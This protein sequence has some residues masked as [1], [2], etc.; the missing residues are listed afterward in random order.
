MATQI[1]GTGQS[2]PY[3]AKAVHFDGVSSQV[4]R[5]DF[6]ANVKDFSAGVLSVWV[7]VNPA[8]LDASGTQNFW[9]SHNKN[10]WMGFKASGTNQPMGASLY[11]DAGGTSPASSMSITT[12]AGSVPANQ[13]AHLFFCWDTSYPSGQKQMACFINGVAQTPATTNDVGPAFQIPYKSDTLAGHF[14]WWELG[15][16]GSSAFLGCDV[17]DLMF[18][19]YL[20]LIGPGNVVNPNDIANFIDSSGNPVSPQKAVAAY[21]TPRVLFSGDQTSFA[22]NRGTGGPFQV[23][24]TLTNASTVPGGGTGAAAASATAPFPM[25]GRLCVSSSVPAGGVDVAA[26]T[27]IYWSPYKGAFMTLNSPTGFQTMAFG[28]IAYPLSATQHAANSCFD[29]FAYINNGAVAL[30]SS[31]AW[32]GTL[33]STRYTGSVN[34]D[35]TSLG[36]WLNTGG[37]VPGCIDGGGNLFTL[38]ARMGVYLGSFRTTSAG[39]TAWVI[40]PG[41]ASGGNPAF[42]YIWNYFNRLPISP[43]VFDNGASYT[44]ANTVCRQARGATNTNQVNFLFGL[45][46]EPIQIDGLRCL[47]T[48]AI[49]SNFGYASWGLDS[50]TAM[51]SRLGQLLTNS[52]LALQA[53]MPTPGILWIGSGYHYVSMN[54]Y[55]ADATNNVSFNLFGSDNL[56]V[57]L[58]A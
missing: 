49:T 16:G 9:T 14:N 55:T 3:T 30:C 32:S 51:G 4:F 47:R 33:T 38:P 42:Q 24:G 20:D 39:T 1:V 37:P 22:T 17:A 10:F 18:W 35:P 13:W 12:A 15:G 48:A 23:G 45:T 25:Q 7:K 26:A 29:L 34:K 19:A 58:N 44:Y 56:Y 46:E 5:N 52:A 11:V 57:T 21:G 6:L 40:N 54:E 43:R 8:T 53:N 28:E 36:L 31:P 27:T 50:T 2:T 41:G